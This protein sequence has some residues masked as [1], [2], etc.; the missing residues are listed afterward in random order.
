MSKNLGL[1]SDWKIL[2]MGVWVLWR[3]A[4]QNN[5]KEDALVVLREWSRAVRDGGDP[6]ALMTHVVNGLHE[7]LIRRHLR[8]RLAPV[9][10]GPCP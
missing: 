7:A 9:H 10:L 6:K 5:L 4:G 3:F 1:N 8:L 2:M